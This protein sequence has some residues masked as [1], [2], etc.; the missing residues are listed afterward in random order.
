MKSL[1]RGCHWVWEKKR[2]CQHWLGCLPSL[3]CALQERW[4]V[5]VVFVSPG[6]VCCCSR[7]ATSTPVHSLT[8]DRVFN[9][10][11]PYYYYLFVFLFT[12]PCRIVLAELENFETEPNQF[13]FHNRGQ[14]LVMLHSGCVFLSV[15]SSLSLHQRT[16]IFGT[17]CMRT[18]GTKSVLFERFAFPR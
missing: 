14:Q 12:L 10:V 5:T 15:K 3:V 6:T 8:I 17:L 1:G 2:K 18:C 4:G 7:C 13:P 16:A 11:Y 9:R